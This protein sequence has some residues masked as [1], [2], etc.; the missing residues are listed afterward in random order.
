MLLG[1]IHGLIGAG[2]ERV[3][4]FAGVREGDA[5]A[6]APRGLTSL[7]AAGDDR[8]LC[9]ARRVSAGADGAKCLAR[10]AP[11]DASFAKRR[12]RVVS[13]EAVLVTR[14]ARVVKSSARLGSG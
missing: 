8:V 13:S 3:G 14:C 6:D 2:D 7:A 5:D 11:W 12:A 9:A 1:A 4:A 10:L